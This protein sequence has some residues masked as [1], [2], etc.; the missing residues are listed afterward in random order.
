MFSNFMCKQESSLLAVPFI[1]LINN[2][3]SQL[4]KIYFLF[5]NVKE[6]LSFQ[7]GLF[8]F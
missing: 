8:V 7:E 3:C 5:F 4:S 6:G 2:V 1:L